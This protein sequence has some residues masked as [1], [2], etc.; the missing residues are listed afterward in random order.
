[1]ASSAIALFPL[2]L[3]T[4]S[5]SSR[6][7]DYGLPGVFS[8]HSAAFRWRFETH[9]LKRV[10]PMAPPDQRELAGLLGEARRI[11]VF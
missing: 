9:C 2:I 4:L 5:P 7:L 10:R 11:E 6:G 3:A 1:M 8:I